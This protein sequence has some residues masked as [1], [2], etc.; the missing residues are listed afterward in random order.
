MTSYQNDLMLDA[1]LIWVRDR[2][3]KENV[4]NALP[5]TYA[6]ATST[7]MLAQVALTSSDATLAAGDSSGRKL[8]MAAKN[9]VSVSTTGTA[10]HVSLTGSTG[11]TLLLVTAC[12]TQA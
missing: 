8:T 6:A 4:N 9:S 7:N 1:A 3:T 5:G 10:S 12:T 2:V 11:S